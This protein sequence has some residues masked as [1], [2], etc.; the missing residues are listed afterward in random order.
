M[1]G[2][3]DTPQPQQ[4][5]NTYNVLHIIHEINKGAENVRYLCDDGFSKIAAFI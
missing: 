3:K 1:T 4:M 2:T 5:V